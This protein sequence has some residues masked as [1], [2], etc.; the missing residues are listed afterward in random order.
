MSRTMQQP[1][2][3]AL[4]RTLSFPGG[5]TITHGSRQDANCVIRL[6][7]YVANTD[8]ATAARLIREYRQ[9]MAN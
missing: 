6:L 8:R 4:F 1:T 2:R 3:Q 5:L 9:Q 7:D